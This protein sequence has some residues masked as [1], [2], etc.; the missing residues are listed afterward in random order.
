MK[1][2]SIIGLGDIKN[3][4]NGNDV[5]FNGILHFEFLSYGVVN[6]DKVWRV[7]FTEEIDVESVLENVVVLNRMTAN[8]L[9]HNINIKLGDNDNELLVSPSD[10][11][12][13]GNGYILKLNTGIKS[14]N[15]NY[16][17]IPCLLCFDIKK[18]NDDSLPFLI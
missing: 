1:I 16:L 11:Y 3:L 4:N 10:N 2:D 9:N 15:G 17:K 13:W 6:I 7:I 8:M 18:E 5:Y 12:V 14:I